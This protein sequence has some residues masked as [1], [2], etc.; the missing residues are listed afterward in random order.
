MTER[1]ETLAEAKKHR[2]T[3]TTTRETVKVELTP[4][5]AEALAAL[6]T[7][8]DGSPTNSPRKLLDGVAAALNAAGVRREQKR[9]ALTYGVSFRDIER[10][11]F[12]LPPL[13]Y[14]TDSVHAAS[15]LTPN[16]RV[17]FKEYPTSWGKV[18]RGEDN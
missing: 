11:A 2:E 15:L 10:A 1:T 13:A 4:R 6:L 14:E 5:E 16:G 7:R 17:A 18:E 12:G 9:P 8:V 3:I